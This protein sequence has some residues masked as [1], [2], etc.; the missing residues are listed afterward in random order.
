MNKKVKGLIIIGL[1]LVVILG[2]AATWMWTIKQERVSKS[3]RIH[4]SIMKSNQDNVLITE[5]E[6][7]TT[8]KSLLKKDIRTMR[9]SQ[10]NLKQ[11]ETA[12]QNLPVIEEVEVFLDAN[13]SVQVQVKQREP[14]FRVVDITGQQYYIDDKG[15]KIPN[16][17]NYSARVPVV[18]GNIPNITGNS[19]WRKE[20]AIFQS[21]FAMTK[22]I[23]DDIFTKSLIEQINIDELMQFSL[24]PKV[25]QEKIV[26]GKLNNTK[27]KLNKLKFFY[28]EGLRYEGWNIYETIDLKNDN[29]V[30]CK[31]Y[32]SES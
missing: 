25:G 17:R 15:N 32:E 6:L 5:S 16:S 14:L 28:Q 7:Y 11:I 30:V 23:N 9:V 27:E 12:L 26:L 8:V 21:V 3:N 31:K 13:N 19:I 4:V 18:T 24:V 22:I 29:Q 20:N 2:I 1:H 10:I